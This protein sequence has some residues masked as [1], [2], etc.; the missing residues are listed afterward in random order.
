MTGGCIMK[1]NQTA[2]RFLEGRIMAITRDLQELLWG[3][4]AL[5]A[6]TSATVL[7]PGIAAAGAP[8]DQE[9]PKSASVGQMKGGSAQEDEYNAYQAIKRDLEFVK[10]AALLFEF[11]E[12]YPN[13]KLLQPIDY[14]HMKMLNRNEYYAYRAAKREPDS[15]KRAVLL[16][17]FLR[18]YPETGLMENRDYE[19]IKPLEDQYDAY[20]AAKQ[21]PD[22]N[23]RAALLIEF[24]RKYPTSALVQ[25]IDYDYV[26]M[27]EEASRGNKYDLLESLAE[28]WL[29]IHPH[30]KNATRFLAEAAGNLKKYE[31]C[32]ESFEEV[33][34][35]EPSSPVAREIYRCYQKTEN[36][37]KQT[38]WAEK[39]SKMPEFEDDYMLRFDLVMRYSKG[40]NLAK[41]A[42]YAQLTLK[43]ADLAG[44]SDTKT[45]EQLRKVHRACHHV[46]ASNLV[47]KR[48]FPEAVFAYK[49]ALKDERYGEGYYGIGLCLDN[50]RE[51][52]EANL[53]YA[54]ADLMG[55]ETAPKAKA[56]LETLYKALH[57]NTLVGIDKVYQ[58]AK[59]SLEGSVN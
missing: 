26:A 52:E 15:D 31:K 49:E 53:Y 32:G 54:M 25:N 6:L 21:E 43:A 18:K 35:M 41:A 23:R 56:R 19:S 4:L 27:L 55:G 24:L 13:S 47:E 39:L 3:V 50:Q 40:K 12:K 9:S 34:K 14:Q 48:N 42:E 57:N 59:E 16:I 38:E 11:L 28:N 44:Q 45:N 7:V 20:D 36:L 51:I 37:A 10:R 5:V 17:E 30:D 29:K 46:I 1:K 2:F 58:K 8:A 22:L 33:Y